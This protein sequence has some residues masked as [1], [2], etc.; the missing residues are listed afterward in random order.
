MNYKTKK[1]L[2]VILAV[3]GAFAVGSNTADVGTKQVYLS[4][5]AIL[6]TSRIETRA[7]FINRV[8]RQRT[9]LSDR[10]LKRLLYIVGFR[11]KYLKEAWA[12][13]KREANGRPRAY[14]GNRSTGDHSYGIF[15]INMIGNLG[16][17]RR[18]KFNL[19]SNA[20]LFNP[21]KN[22]KIAYYMSNGGKNWSSWH[23]INAKAKI[24]M[25]EFPS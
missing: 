3:L 18:D 24:W 15:Q 22:A 10:Q 13:A 8:S 21:V 16:A 2:I 17:A 14:N 6:I 19:K 25:K 11:G 20:E 4:D 1:I 9:K 7:D 12:I 5:A 23:G